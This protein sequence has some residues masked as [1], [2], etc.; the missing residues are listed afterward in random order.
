MQGHMCH[1][2]AHVTARNPTSAGST[3]TN[4]NPAG[5]RG[6]ACSMEIGLAVVTSPTVL[7]ALAAMLLAALPGLLA[8]LIG[9]LLSAALLLARLLLAALLV[10]RILVLLRH[11][12]VHALLHV[13]ARA[14]YVYP[15]TLAPRRHQ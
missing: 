3:I 2:R 8:L 12:L 10:L 9:P 13:A 1:P 14:G 4:E 6:F 11:A 5:R 15:R 7:A